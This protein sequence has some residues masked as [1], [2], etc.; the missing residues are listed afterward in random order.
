V[1]KIKKYLKR[2][3]CQ[4]D[5]GDGLLQSLTLAY[6]RSFQGP[7]LDAEAAF[8]IER[9]TSNRHSDGHF[10]VT[11][12]GARKDKHESV[13]LSVQERVAIVLAFDAEATQRCQAWSSRL[14]AAFQ[15]EA[16]YSRLRVCTKTGR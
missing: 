14:E 12:N 4:P 2:H 15:V 9:K 3:T 5:I 11:G 16:T 6:H 13:T 8:G 1:G 10:F 7:L